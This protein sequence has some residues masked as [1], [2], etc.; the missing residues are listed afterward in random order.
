MA[1]NGARVVIV[2]AIAVAGVLNANEFLPG[3]AKMMHEAGFSR[4]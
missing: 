2:L 1:P 3:L 4:P